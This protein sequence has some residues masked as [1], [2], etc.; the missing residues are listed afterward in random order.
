MKHSTM[1]KRVAEKRAQEKRAL[2]AERKAQAEAEALLECQTI[3]K[4]IW[5]A[6]EM[7][8][9]TSRAAAYAALQSDYCRFAEKLVPAIMTDSERMKVVLE[10]EE[11]MKGEAAPHEDPRELMRQW[12]SGETDLSKIP[13]EKKAVM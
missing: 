1:E 8:R 5:R 2:E 9:K 4:D 6:F 7:R 13:L 11:Y 12:L 3:Y 10:C